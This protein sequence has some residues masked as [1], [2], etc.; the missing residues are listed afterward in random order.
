[1]PW[2]MPPD[3]SLPLYTALRFAGVNVRLDELDY[4]AGDVYSSGFLNAS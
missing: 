1:M 3:T 2:V 4:F